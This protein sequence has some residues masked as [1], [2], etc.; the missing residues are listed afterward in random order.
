MRV[1]AQL[2]SPLGLVM[3]FCEGQPMAAKPNLEVRERRAGWL[4]G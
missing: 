2:Q 4:K 1:V 3:E